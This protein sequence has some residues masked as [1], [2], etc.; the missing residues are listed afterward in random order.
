MLTAKNITLKNQ[1]KELMDAIQHA[2]A[3]VA[4]FIQ[5]R[6]RKTWE[7]FTIAYLKDNGHSRTAAS[8]H[9]WVKNC[10]KPEKVAKGEYLQLPPEIEALQ[11][12][13]TKQRRGRN[14]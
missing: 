9:R 2:R 14:A 10:E 12:K 13:T 6:T 5:T 11:T 7:A 4:F 3:A 8:L 1:R